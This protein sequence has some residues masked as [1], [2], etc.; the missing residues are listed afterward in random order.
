[1]SRAW[2]IKPSELHLINRID[3]ENTG[4]YGDIY[5]AQYRNFQVAVKKLRVALRECRE[6]REFEREIV[7]MPSIRHRNIVL[8][9]G[10]GRSNNDSCPF[11]VVQ[12]MEHGALS[13][14]LHD[15]S[16]DLTKSQQLRVCLDSA[17]RVEFLHSLRPP[18]IHRD[19]KIINLL[20]SHD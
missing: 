12:Y 7:L 3:E 14:M 2:N 8:F 17:K 1:M 15:R 13:G 6:E 10:A 11:F 9:L 19:I 20:V 4:S 16:I 18:R 5:R